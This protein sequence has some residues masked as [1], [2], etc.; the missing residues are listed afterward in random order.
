MAIFDYAATAE[1]FMTFGGSWKTPAMTYKRFESAAQAVQFA[2][3]SLSSKQRLAT[4]MEVTE[5]RYDASAIRNLYE[6]RD[7]PLSRN[8]N[9]E[10]RS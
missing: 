8:V 9:N 4:V 6:S 7:Y 5:A 2:M 1:L 10:K 3:E